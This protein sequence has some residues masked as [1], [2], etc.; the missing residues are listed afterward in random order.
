MEDNVSSE[1]F[2]LTIE[3]KQALKPTP[4]WHYARISLIRMVIDRTK[5]KCLYNEGLQWSRNGRG[6]LQLQ[7]WGEAYTLYTT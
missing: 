2:L 1:Q 3:I 7:K 5:A 4:I 6:R